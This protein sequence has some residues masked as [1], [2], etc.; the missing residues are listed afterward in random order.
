M[1]RASFAKRLYNF[2]R[3]YLDNSLD[4]TIITAIINK[5]GGKGACTV[6]TTNKVARYLFS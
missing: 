2:D 4:D 3:Q 5:S 1:R 6:I